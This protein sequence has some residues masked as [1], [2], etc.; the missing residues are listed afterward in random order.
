MLNVIKC[1]AL[2]LLY[3]ESHFDM[4]YGTSNMQQQFIRREKIMIDAHSRLCNFYSLLNYMKLKYLGDDF[5]G[6]HFTEFVCLFE[7]SGFFKIFDISF[8]KK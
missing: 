2:V 1:L 7:R 5:C 4:N 8:I 3:T 6:E